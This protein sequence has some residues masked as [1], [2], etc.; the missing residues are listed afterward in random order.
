MIRYFI[1]ATLCS[2]LLLLA[3]KIILEK[4]TMHRFKRFYLLSAIL[5]SYTVPFIVVRKTISTVSQEFIRTEYLAENPILTTD[6]IYWQNLVIGVFGLISLLLFVRLIYNLYKVISKTNSSRRRKFQNATLVLIED[7][8]MPH[9]FLNY[10]FIGEQGFSNCESEKEILH[11]E[12]AHVNQKHSYDILFLELTLCLFWINPFLC[13]YKKSIQLNHEFLA[14][15]EVNNYFNNVYYYQNLL[16]QKASMPKAINIT[17]QF[18]YQVIKK[19][20]IMMTKATPGKIKAF[21]LFTI[22]PIVLVSLYIF[23]RNV[24][25][26]QKVV[27]QSNN[28]TLQDSVIK[29]QTTNIKRN[30]KRISVVNTDKKRLTKFSPI[31]I[32]LAKLDENLGQLAPLNDC[33]GS[34]KNITQ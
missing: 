3:Y 34:L 19:R 23:G 30:A 4:E 9:S 20:I 11:H 1:Y 18:N 6:T 5:F 25:L 16:L 10:I 29:P 12:L 13:L 14:D 7:D 22:L 31:K 2:G 8:Q 17:S 32:K 27:T 26:Q 28:I 24:V 33:L 21:K 15:E